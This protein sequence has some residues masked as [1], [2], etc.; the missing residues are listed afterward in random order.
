MKLRPGADG[1]LAT[2]RLRYKEP[3]TK[4]VVESQESLG[5]GQVLGSA[6]DASPSYRLAAS[7]AQF[8]EILR[9]GPRAKAVTLGRVLEEA[10]RASEEL[11]HPED[12]VEFTQ[13]VRRAAGL[14][15]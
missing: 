5:M 9:E 6:G 12:A 11:G 1:R 13:L 7:V 4:E 8:A 3:D 14:K 2:V 15:K 10:S